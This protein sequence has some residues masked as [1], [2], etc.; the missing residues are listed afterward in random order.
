MLVWQDFT[1]T[2][3]G[4]RFPI[5][6]AIRDQGPAPRLASGRIHCQLYPVNPQNKYTVI[7][8]SACPPSLRYGGQSPAWFILVGPG[9]P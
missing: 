3:A 1:G 9:N 6:I 4:L 2:K 5:P 7:T 8:L